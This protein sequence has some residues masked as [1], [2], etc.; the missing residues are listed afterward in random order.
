MNNRSSTPLAAVIRGAP[1][2]AQVG[3]RLTEGLFRAKYNAKTLA[4]D[5]SAHLVFGLTT[6]AVFRISTKGQAR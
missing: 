3:R 5:L 4:N 6:A 2:P 1:A